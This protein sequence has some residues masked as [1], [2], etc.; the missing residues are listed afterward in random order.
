MKKEMIISFIVG[1]AIG[2]AISFYFI[3][4]LSK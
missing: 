3:L 4:N 2:L 1:A